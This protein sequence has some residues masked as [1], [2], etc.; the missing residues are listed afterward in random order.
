MMVLDWVTVMSSKQ[1][2]LFIISTQNN[3][4]STYIAIDT[5]P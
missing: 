4:I 3:A 5:H 1:Y 2:V